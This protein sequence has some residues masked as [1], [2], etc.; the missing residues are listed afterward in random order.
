M[1]TLKRIALLSLAAT[2]FILSA[3][4]SARGTDGGG[5]R[6]NDDD[7]SVGGVEY[8]YWGATGA[9][10]DGK[11]HDTGTTTGDHCGTHKLANDSNAHK[12]C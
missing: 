4:G 6:C 1:T 7:G 5:D 9:C 12:A 11:S 2:A 3:P 8:H 10:Y